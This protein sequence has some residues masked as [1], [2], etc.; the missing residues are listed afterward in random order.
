[1]PK[2]P[3][4]RGTQSQGLFYHR[5]RRSTG[6]S[7]N[8][9]WFSI[10]VVVVARRAQTPFLCSISSIAFDRTGLHE[11]SALS[12]TGGSETARYAPILITDKYIPYQAGLPN[13]LSDRWHPKYWISFMHAAPDTLRNAL[14][15]HIKPS[16]QVTGA[17]TA[18]ST[19]PTS[20]PQILL[21]GSQELCNIA[22]AKCKQVCLW[23]PSS[24]ALIVQAGFLVLLLVVWPHVRG[25]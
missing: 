25:P 21:S 2:G 8:K 3:Q 17:C 23:Y 10:A 22:I 1:M 18:Y 4:P 19:Q 24:C 11:P 13:L 20:Q 15:E 7:G 16:S 14:R 12:R 5:L 6:S 9:P